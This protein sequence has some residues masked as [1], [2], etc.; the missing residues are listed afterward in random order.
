MFREST[1]IDATVNFLFCIAP[2]MS[3]NHSLIICS[4]EQFKVLS[5]P[6]LRIKHK[7]KLTAIDGSKA[8]KL[9]VIALKTQKD[10]G[11]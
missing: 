6:Q 10:K 8:R 3:G 11:L 9:G 5:L 1:T 7:E 2:D 4:E